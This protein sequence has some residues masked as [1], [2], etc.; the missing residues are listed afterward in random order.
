MNTARALRVVQTTKPAPI[1][2]ARASAD[3]LNDV[4]SFVARF[5][6]FPS[7]HC[8]PTLAL[9]YAHTHMAERFYV[10]PR[11]ILDSAEPGSGK[12]RVLEVAQFLVA[13]PEMT[14]SAK[15][16]AL[17]RLVQ[18]GPITILFDEVDTIFNPK[19]SGNGDNDDLRAM[20]NAGYKRS[21]T[22]P[23]CVGDVKAM[24]VKRFK[25]Y[26]P[27]V[28]AG[29][30]GGMP[31]TITTRAIT[32]HMRRRRP[33]EQVDQFREKVVEREAEL[34]REALASWV[35]SVADQVSDAE[36]EMP[37][38]VTD[39][40]AEIW[41]PLLALADAAGDH[42][43]DTARNAC[44]HFVLDT[45]PQAGSLGVRLLADLRELYATREVDRMPTSDILAALIELDEAPWPDLYGRPLDAR[46][47]ARELGRYG[48]KPVTFEIDGGGSV[49]GYVTFGTAGKQA[50][51]GLA[52]AWS[53][54]L[55]A[56]ISKSGK[57]G[58]QPGQLLT[59]AQSLTGPV[60]SAHRSVSP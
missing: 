59:Y 31:A 44:R 60:A 15:P 21:A 3:V 26:A 8:V 5:N 57:S 22:I 56:E 36:P 32:I 24:Q 1:A 40:S 20:L 48:V 11:L 35:T 27:A 25:V 55:P 14:I 28:L 33:D 4:A 16:A 51:A 38:G 6:V 23:R 47:L 18:A 17:F 19:T 41:E 9:W 54:Y 7:E 45:G 39:R 53:R 49:K 43:P 2:R 13:A 34:I 29:I 12:T 58:K 50:Q 42:W 46:R 30:T 10:T 52:D 37:H